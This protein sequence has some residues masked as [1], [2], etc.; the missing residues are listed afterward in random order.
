MRF[1]TL[2]KFSAL[3]A[4]TLLLGAGLVAEDE[5][6]TT[7]VLIETTKGK[8]TVEL[9]GEKAPETVKNFLQYVDDGFYEGI[10]FHRVISDFMIQTGG[11]ELKDGGVV[12][13]KET[14]GSIKNEAANGLKNARGTIAMARTRDPHSAS[15]QFFINLK[16]NSFLDHPGQDGW[17]YAV[18]GK[19]V[20]GMDVVDAIAEVETATRELHA[21]AGGATAPRPMGDVPVEDVVILSAKRVASQ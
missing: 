9:D 17:G 16:D 8:I 15:A 6:A 14:R 5:S 7:R 1:L 4:G 11:F 18:F 21:R 2:P 12:E 10:V 3:L 20:E 13:E 19:V